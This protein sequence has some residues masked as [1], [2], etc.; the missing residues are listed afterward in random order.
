MSPI[1]RIQDALQFIDPTAR[2]TWVRMGMAIKSEL[3]EDGFDL[4]ESWSQQADSFNDKDTRST[5]KSIRVGGGGVTIGTLFH[6]AQANG[7]R[8]DGSYQKQT[9]EELAERRRIA[10]E[11]E[12][13]DEAD[14]AKEREQTSAWAAMIW[15]SATE[16]KADHPYLTRKQISPV[17]TLREALAGLVSEILGYVPKS[18][19]E[20]L[21][22]RLLVIPVVQDRQIATLELI[23]ESGRKT[24]LAGRGTKTGGFWATARLPTG[25]GA[26]L[27]L[28]IGEG[29]A[30]V[31]SASEAT[32]QPAVASLSSGNLQAVAKLMRERYPAAALVILADLVKKTGEPDSHAIEAAR[33]VN[34]LLAVPD[35]VTARQYDMTD[36]NDMATIC[37]SEAVAQAITNANE[38]AS[39]ETSS[40]FDGNGWPAPQPLA[41]KIEPAEP[42]PLDALPDS[43]RAA[44][45]EVVGFVKAPVPLVASSALA[46][47]S[48]ACQA[49]IDAKRAEK[50]HGP[51]G[52]FLLTIADSGDRKSTCDGFF[53]QAIRDYVQAQAESAKPAQEIYRAELKAWKAKCDGVQEKIR[54]LAKNNKPTA[55]MES[56][57]RGL[58]HNKPEQPRV[59]RLL[60][61]DATPEALAYSL[62]KQWPSGGVVSAEAGIVFGSHGMGKDSLMRN[63]GLLN[64]LWDGTSLTIDRRSSESFTVRGARLTV[65][66]QV[67][68]QTLREFFTRSGALARGTGFLAR[69]L[70]AWPEST[71]GQRPFTD[72]PANWPHL[73][74]FHR[75]IATILDQPVPI[76]ED[77]ALT[78]AMLSLAPDAKAAWVEYYNGIERELSSSG[79]F[80]DV[81]DV[82]SKS[83]DNAARL[84]AL[85]Q[86]FEE[87]KDAIGLAAFR[88]ASFIAAWHLRESRR[89]FVELSRPAKLTD[90]ARL[91][92]W[93][94][95]YCQQECKHLVSTREAQ[96]F[97]PI[98]IKENLDIAIFELE[99]LGRLKVT[100]DGSRISI[101]LNPAL[102]IR[103][104]SVTDKFATATP[105]TFATQ[106]VERGRTVATVTTVAVANPL[107]ADSGTVEVEI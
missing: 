48:L 102:L 57:L 52:V 42:Y 93:L 27:T 11:R 97:G 41:A 65:A 24:A 31:L 59:P 80:Y 51:V 99:E 76:D 53:T 47:L 46:A 45:E 7:W 19:G 54:Q 38:P 1:T 78:P 70:V 33:S 62:S 71:Q 26:G 18:G 105:A 28:L 36:F 61:A 107:R 87:S 15:K 77:G 32:V 35:F 82:A 88:S 39:G 37:G 94:I 55:D 104:M 89:F 50:L 12:Q 60:Y 72:P 73:A 14:I 34:G 5:W 68:E 3:N 100:R 40:D 69:F 6:E 83:A 74:A 16:A 22:G 86:M 2:D 58:E 21:A 63:L 30:T 43:I 13:Q 66:L 101:K 29:V 96:R 20:P 98:R 67:Q 9:S 85:F 64:Q 84:A 79:E 25:N 44:I 8:D 106:E 4:W 75:R 10:A 23:D 17:S 103:E 81:R 90:A 91:D 56:A 95:K 49:H 92:S